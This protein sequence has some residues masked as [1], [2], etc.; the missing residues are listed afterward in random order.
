M[1]D[2]RSIKKSAKIIY[3]QLYKNLLYL[4]GFL[5]NLSVKDWCLENIDIVFGTSNKY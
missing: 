2:A 4:I 3:W 1:I 5:L